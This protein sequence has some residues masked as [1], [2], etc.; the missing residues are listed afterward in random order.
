M[1]ICSNEPFAVSPLVEQ[2]ILLRKHINQSDKWVVT[3]NTRFS[4]VFPKPSKRFL[5]LP[6][7]S[8]LPPVIFTK[9]LSTT[10]NSSE[11]SQLVN[12]WLPSVNPIELLGRT[13]NRKYFPGQ[14]Q[15]SSQ[16]THQTTGN[17]HFS[18]TTP[19]Y[20]TG[21]IAIHNTFQYC[22]CYQWMLRIRRQYTDTFSIP[23]YVQNHIGVVSRAVS[24]DQHFIYLLVTAQDF[25]Q[26][27]VATSNFCNYWSRPR[28]FCNYWSRPRIF[29]NYWS[30]P[31][32]FCNS[33]SHAK[34]FFVIPGHSQ[35]IFCN[36]WSRPRIFSMFWSQPSQPR[37]FSMF[38]LKSR[39]LAMFWSQPKNFSM[40][41]SNIEICLCP[42]QCL[43]IFLSHVITWVKI[44]GRSYQ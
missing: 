5:T 19:I 28:I 31:R 9:F 10:R 14:T 23:P 16:T 6:F 33:W 2:N 30:R 39:N 13:T 1:I 34:V 21:R 8:W 18:V 12:S 40:F 3:D 11:P 32:I 35:G 7:N 17:S 43:E 44:F 22:D 4:P 36:S 42:R 24:S 27:L 26:V 41:W 37:I 20:F 38:W 29:C 15:Q 25:L